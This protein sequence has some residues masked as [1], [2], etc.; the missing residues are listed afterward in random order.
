MKG[1]RDEMNVDHGK[2]WKEKRIEEE[3]KIKVGNEEEKWISG[4]RQ[5][6]RI[7]KKEPNNIVILKDCSVFRIE[8]IVMVRSVFTFI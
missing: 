7:E 2:S 6:M 5:R 3:A 8:N 4:E 1:K